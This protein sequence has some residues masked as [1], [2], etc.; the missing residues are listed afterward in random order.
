MKKPF[1]TFGV[2]PIR[3]SDRAVAEAAPADNTLTMEKLLKAAALLPPPPAFTE[4]CCNEKMIPDARLCGF[5]VVIS[6]LV[7]VGC[8]I[9]MKPG[10]FG[11]EVAGIIGPEKKT[12]LDAS[13]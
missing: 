13:K 2:L 1:E 9:A 3:R 6:D 5:P 12:D 7:P 4:L 8:I 10:P 11:P